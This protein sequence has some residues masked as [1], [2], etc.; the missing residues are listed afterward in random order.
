MTSTNEAELAK[1]LVEK[2]PAIQFIAGKITIV[3]VDGMSLV[4]RV[5][6]ANLT[7]GKVLKAVLTLI[8]GTVF[9]MTSRDNCD[10]MTKKSSNNCL[11][12]NSS[13]E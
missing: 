7:F 9:F 10:L 6:C 2:V 8:K 4:H 5:N 1:S 13:Q 11:M 12:L 3:I